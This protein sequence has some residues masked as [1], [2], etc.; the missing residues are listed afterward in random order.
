MYHQ[1]TGDTGKQGPVLHGASQEK[2]KCPVYLGSDFPSKT[3]LQKGTRPWE[4]YNTLGQEK[5]HH[6]LSY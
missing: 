5:L 2:A 3:S 1:Q 6:H 4:Q